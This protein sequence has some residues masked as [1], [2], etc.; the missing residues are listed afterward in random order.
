MLVFIAGAIILGH[1]Q[2][3]NVVV[4]ISSAIPYAAFA[5]K[6]AVAGATRNTSAFFASAT[7]STLYWKF[8]S[9]VSTIHLL[10]VRV[11]NVMGL[12]KLTAFCVII[13]STLQLSLTKLLA[14]LAI[15]YAAILPVTPNI[16][17]LPLSICASLS[18]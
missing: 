4:S 9:K 2:A 10:P 18:I 3:R 12:I 17:F 5:R 1:L 14:R 7:C 16:T 13:T 11:S 15:L 8:L 6:L